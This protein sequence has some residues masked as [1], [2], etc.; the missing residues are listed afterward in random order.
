[1]ANNFAELIH[2]ELGVQT[3]LV[4]HLG[5]GTVVLTAM[6]RNDADNCAT[7]YTGTDNSGTRCMNPVQSPTQAMTIVQRELQKRV[8]TTWY[9]SYGF[10]DTVAYLVTTEEAQKDNRLNI[11]D[12]KKV[13]TQ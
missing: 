10:S 7:R 2:H 4:K 5:S 12:S 3:T 6:I 9:P 11:S 1:M 8:D 13:A